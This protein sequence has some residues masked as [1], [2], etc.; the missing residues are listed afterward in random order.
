MSLSVPQFPHLSHRAEGPI[1]GGSRRST[2]CLRRWC[3]ANHGAPLHVDSPSCHWGSIPQSTMWSLLC[4]LPVTRER[5][6]LFQSK[7]LVTCD[8][9]STSRLASS[10][11]SS[12]ALEG[13]GGWWGPLS[14][15]TSPPSPGS[16]LS[17][18]PL[19]LV[20]LLGELGGAQTHS[21]PLPW[22]GPS[23]PTPLRTGPG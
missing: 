11:Q 9:D 2:P 18:C 12:Q 10:V 22:P 21:I 5:A 20:G 14:E 4:C 7:G 17:S 3:L 1:S 16:R 8:E 15:G 23:P 6:F 13:P 19:R